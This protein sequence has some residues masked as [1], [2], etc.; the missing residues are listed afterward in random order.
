MNSGKG[1]KGMKNLAMQLGLSSYKHLH[2][3]S[4]KYNYKFHGKSLEEIQ[5]WYLGI[6]KGISLPSETLLDS[7]E[8]LKKKA[9]ADLTYKIETAKLAELKRK[10]I[11]GDLVDLNTVA[12]VWQQ[13]VSM[14]KA[15]LLSL[16]IKIAEE[17]VALNKPSV[18]MIEII[19]DKYIIEVLTE[20]ANTPIP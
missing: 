10:Q 12:Q 18:K 19:V 3:I 6:K 8:I 14:T 16:P 15:Q 20:L 1:W 11:E 13:R 5:D 9:L 7:S 17:V 2:G 4:N